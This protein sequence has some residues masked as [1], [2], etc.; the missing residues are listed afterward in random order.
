MELRLARTALHAGRLRREGAEV[1]APGDLAHEAGGEQVAQQGGRGLGCNAQSWRASRAAVSAGRRRAASRASGRRER[2]SRFS[3]AALPR[4]AAASSRPSSRRPASAASRASRQNAKGH[5]A[6]A[7]PFPGQWRPSSPPAAFRLGRGQGK[8]PR[9]AAARPVARPR[10]TAAPPR[11]TGPELR[12]RRPPTK[13]GQPRPPRAGAA[14]APR[15]HLARPAHADGGES[16]PAPSGGARR[17]GRAPVQSGERL[18]QLRAAAEWVAGAQQTQAF[19][20]SREA[21][22]PAHGVVG[23]RGGERFLPGGSAGVGPR[24]PTDAGTCGQGVRHLRPA[25]WR[26][27]GRM[28]WR[29]P[30]PAARG[31]AGGP[32]RPGWRA[33]RRPRAGRGGAPGPLAPVHWSR[34]PGRPSARARPMRQARDRAGRPG[35]AVPT[36]TPRPRWRGEN[37]A[38]AFGGAQNGAAPTSSSP[39]HTGR[40]H[41]SASSTLAFPFRYSPTLFAPWRCTTMIAIPNRYGLDR[42]ARPTLSGWVLQ[43]ASAT[44][45]R[46]FPFGQR[47]RD[48]ASHNL[49]KRRRHSGRLNWMEAV[50]G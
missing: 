18:H 47:G 43:C 6:P 32:R 8:P 4:S 11:R 41:S 29:G 49:A 33:S 14:A 1:L 13:P 50:L 31:R 45:L 21:Q 34:L 25:R 36:A 5:A 24:V 42:L 10:A 16:G 2:R 44:P 27:R 7:R 9:R 28:G 19:Q 35:R 48:Q 12:T 15:P 46:P 37:P 17:V 22:S 20:R 3:V 38:I 40:N 23:L 39:S 30:R 26:P